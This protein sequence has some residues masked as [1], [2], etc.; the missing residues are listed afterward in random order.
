MQPCSTLTQEVPSETCQ[1]SLSL[2]KQV[3]SLSAH[4]VPPWGLHGEYGASGRCILTSPSEAYLSP[5][6]L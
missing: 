5:T 6:P 4:E 1:G 3:S 2:G